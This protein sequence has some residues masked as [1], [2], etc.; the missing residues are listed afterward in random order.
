MSYCLEFLWFEHNVQILIYQKMYIFLYQNSNIMAAPF[1][2]GKIAEGNNFIDRENDTKRLAEN[3]MSLT[4]TILISPRRWGK[5]SLVH[6]AGKEAMAKDSNL[7]IVFIDIFNV[8]TEDEFYSKLAS[9]VLKQTA[10]SLDN[11]M[12]AVKKYASAIVSGLSFGDAAA[13]TSI[14]F[15]IREPKMSIDEILDLPEKIAADRKMKIV[16][17]IDEFQQIG[18]FESPKAFQATLRSKWQLQQ[19]VSYCL[20]GSR[21]HMMMEVFG[22]VSMPFYKFG[23]IYFLEKID[24]LFW[25]DYIS[26]EFL[27]TGKRIT[28]GQCERIVQLAD[29]NPYYVQQLAQTTWLHCQSDS[30]TDSDIT[31]AFEDILRQQGELNRALTLSLTISQQNLL[32]AMS[33]GEK[34]L[35]SQRVMKE[36]RLK[37][38]TEVSRARKALIANDILDD[39]GKQYSFEDPI[40][41]YWLKNVFFKD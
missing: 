3:F 4:N 2:F 8:R 32:H 36:Y 22:K 5:S 27:N 12:T 29:N 17:C 19:H 26:R 25:P 16:I 1:I 6:K 39:F 21:R 37:S 23:A 41:E 31:D 9:E 11:I 38:S 20:Y 30:C 13:P 24:R 15:Q 33:A 28:E 18:M 35:S 7:K 40:Y 34:N 10:S 14:Q